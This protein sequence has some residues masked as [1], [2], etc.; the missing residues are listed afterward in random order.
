MLKT[1]NIK[2]VKNRKAIVRFS[3]DSRVGH[4]GSKIIDDKI[5]NKVEVDDEFEKKG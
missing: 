3:G 4:A 1:S 2:S 5:D